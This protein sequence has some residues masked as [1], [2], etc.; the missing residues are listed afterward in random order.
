MKKFRLK[1]QRYFWMYD[2]KVPFC[3]NS[4][5][6]NY[7]KI[8]FH[9]I[10]NYKIY[11]QYNKKNLFSPYSYRYRTINHFLKFK[12]EESKYN[13][14]LIFNK[15][16]A[17]YSN[18]DTVLEN[19]FKHQIQY[20]P[21]VTF[22]Y[23]ISL[24]YRVDCHISLCKNWDSFISDSFLEFYEN[25]HHKYKDDIGASYFTYFDKFMPNIFYKNYIK[26]RDLD[27]FDLQQEV[28]RL[29]WLD[30]NE[31][32][33]DDNI[34]SF[35]YKYLTSNLENYFILDKELKTVE[36]LFQPQAV[37]PELLAMY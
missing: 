8:P 25:Y 13:Y 29:S 5:G 15:L 30:E 36:K 23:S 21:L 35:S 2:I 27:S 33:T 7:H 17:A 22:M 26:H 14:D 10:L 3:D 16:Y 6:M 11:K 24:F 9:F 20:V 18:Y 31:L 37:S 34:S 32:T 4:P 12:Y 1:W 19:M 28:Y